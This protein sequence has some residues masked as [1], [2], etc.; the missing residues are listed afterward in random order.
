MMTNKQ[1]LKVL[2]LLFILFSFGVEHS[3]AQT[4]SSLVYM[5]N[6]S[7]IY[8]PF[9]MNGQTNSINTIPDFSH[10]GYKAGGIA[11]PNVPVALTISPV[12]GDDR[13]SI[14]DAIDLVESM[15]LDANGFRGA[16][17]LTA[18]SYEVDGILTI[19]ASGVVIRGEG[20]GANG[21]VIHANQTT[22]HDFLSMQG[23]GSGIIKDSNTT[24]T[25]TS[26]YVPVG[27]Y[28][29]DIASAS[30]YTVG[31][32][33]SV[34]RTP[35]QY[36]IDDLGVGQYGWTYSSYSINHERVITAISGNTL[37]I[38]LPVVDVMESQYGGGTVSKASIPGRINNC[39]VE[40]LRIESYYTSSTDENHAWILIKLKRVVNSWVKNVT[41]QY[42]GY[43][44]VSIENESNFNTIQDCA[45]ID[46]KSIV[47]GG[48]RYSFNISDGLGN[49]LQRCYTRG[50]R[51]DYVTG[52]RVTGPNVFLDCYATNTSND[53]G[54]HH[55][56]S[57]GL[58]FDNINGGDINV[59]N[60]GSSGSGHGW[61]GSSVMLWNSIANQSSM[62][63]SSPKGGQN[64]GIGGTGSTKVGSGFWEH[65]NNPVTPRSLYLQQLEDRLGT[66]A[67][68]NITIPE[69]LTGNIHTMLANWA[70]EGPLQIPT[71][72]ASTILLAIE[73]AFVR[74]G[75]NANSNY[76]TAT[77]LVVK[78]NSGSA[79]NDRMSF[80]KFDLSTI[81]GQVSIAK[82]KIKVQNDD[83]GASHSLY[84]RN[85][86]SWTE[87]GITWNN[88]PSAGSLISTQTVP[89][90]GEWIEFDVT[91]EVNA[92]RAGDGTISV[93]LSESGINHFVG[94]HSLNATSADNHPRLTY[95]LSPP[96]SYLGISEDAYVQ[97][98]TAADNNYGTSNQL[99]IKNADPNLVRESY[100][101]FDLSSL[102]GT[103]LS[104]KVRL[105]VNNDD[106]GVIT[107]AISFVSNDSWSEVSITWNNKP[108]VGSLLSE[109]TV[110]LIGDWLEFDVLAQAQTELSGDGVLSLNLSETS[111]NHY[112]GYHSS[113]ASA[114]DRPQL[115][116]ELAPP[117]ISLG[118]S[119]DA[120]V[121]GGTAANNNYGSNN[122]IVVK[123]NGNSS[124]VR[125]SYLKFDLSGITGTL[126]SAK[127]R[128]MVANDDP[129]AITHA[130]SNVSNDSWSEGS[131]TWNN[132]PAIGSLLSSETVPSIGNW[133]EFDVLA[134]AQTELSGDGILSVNLSETSNN[135]FIGYHS[136][137]SSNA[138]HR[139]E[140]V[141]T[142]SSGSRVALARP[143]I[144]EEVK[145][146]Y[147]FRQ[148]PNPVNN[149]KAYFEFHLATA[150]T[151]N[152][153]VYDIDGRLVKNVQRELGKG[154]HLVEL[155]LNLN[156]GLFIYR[157]SSDEFIKEGKMIIAEH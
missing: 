65:W 30:G 122:Q 115:I 63:V 123:Y 127:I 71:D 69:Q 132:K 151:V 80:L 60:R 91:D 126:T 68:S 149:N 92:A 133:L 1:P 99:V 3:R 95:E 136:S 74:G 37:T 150:N 104:A 128:L 44:T 16:V 124:Y 108:A 120:Y 62:E 109:N 98:G 27:A 4:S 142:T 53:I 9:A 70:G 19:E 40:N 113:E 54:P 48:R 11:L 89:N 13:Q 157:I 119:E 83:S 102:S 114:D 148:Y 12:A 47:T 138:D 73:D 51:H 85:D 57:T 14:Q 100:L 121:Q 131:I 2:L 82:I 154:N 50:G 32:T 144:T 58:L 137:E 55:R 103:L 72:T 143:N 78:E 87:T 125:E 139:P 112:I 101:K 36:W 105:K 77:T 118:V 93:Q 39:G 43:G 135:H 49:L 64:W 155:D 33:I 81:S 38:N 141:Y 29:F 84:T 147:S 56:W 5:D 145:M 67:V 153:V 24:Q 61:V 156:K 10:A 129:G 86:D 76:G 116:Y 46:H 26:S 42:M 23:S 28:S 52:S 140:L 35:N 94:Y 79:D 106:T 25:I 18:G 90:I 59:R 17:L 134:Q 15:S 97:D 110:P 111:L 146:D 75:A 88:K 34:T 6:D 22:Q 130:I 152:I 7:L 41:G 20:Q 45:S 66:S 31:D 8:T 21:T 107:H 117:P 96:S